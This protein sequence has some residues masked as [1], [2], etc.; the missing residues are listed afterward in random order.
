MNDKNFSSE[1][2]DL[3]S[4]E[5]QI[6]FFKELVED[7]PVEDLQMLRDSLPELSKLQQKIDRLK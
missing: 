2:F 5:D 4:E 6:K 1:A 3:L 7:I